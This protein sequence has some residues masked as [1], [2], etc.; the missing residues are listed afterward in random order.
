[1]LFRSLESSPGASRLPK[2]DYLTFSSAGG[3][4]S[5][6]EQYDAVPEGACCVCIGNVT[7]R[8]LVQHTD[9]YF[10]TASEI[11]GEISAAG[12]VEAILRDRESS[13]GN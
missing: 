2:L 5:Y 7:A 3:V 8:A 9:A 11:S 4:K 10:L 1:M 13:S 12:I 6:F